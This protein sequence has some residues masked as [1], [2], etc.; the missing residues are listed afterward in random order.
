M[1]RCGCSGRREEQFSK[2]KTQR[3][4]CPLVRGGEERRY[5]R[6]G[7]ERIRIKKLVVKDCGV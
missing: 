5:G 6:W 2:L 3:I 1:V 4:Y 7:E